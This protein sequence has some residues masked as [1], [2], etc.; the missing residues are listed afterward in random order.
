[1]S[2]TYLIKG[3]SRKGMQVFTYSDISAANRAAET[4]FT[5]SPTTV[6]ASDADLMAKSGPA[7]VAL[8]NGLIDDADKAI[9]RFNNRG[10]GARRVFTLLVEKYAGQPVESES[11]NVDQADAKSAGDT[12]TNN[13]DDMAT[14]GKKVKKAAKAK[15]AKAPREKKVREPRAKK[16]RSYKAEVVSKGSKARMDEALALISRKTGATAEEIKDKL[17]VSLGTAKN[18][19]W[20]LRRDGNKIVV[21]A[22]AESGRRPYV[23]A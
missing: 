11:K 21:G 20:Y 7:L 18:L 2:V 4:R 23:I 8:Y 10:D 16:D 6:A 3:L 15:V 14:K 9:E 12:E 17:G 1:M 13:E 22:K 5:D 19:V